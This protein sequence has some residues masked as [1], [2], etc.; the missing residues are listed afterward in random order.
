MYT[1]IVEKLNAL[2]GN[3]DHISAD[4]TFAENWQSIQFSGYLYDK[5]WDVYGIDAFYEK[6]K[7][8]YVDHNEKFY[9]DLIEHYFSEHEQTYG[10]DFYKDW[11][12]TPFKKDSK[13]D[14]ELDGFVEEDEL[15]KT[16]QGTEMDFICIIYSYGYPDHYFVCLTDPNPINPTVYST[17]H[18]VYFQ[19]IENEGSL[20]DFLDRYMTKEAFVGVV[21]EYLEEKFGK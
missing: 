7:E 2:G 15:R 19:K 1:K 9:E 14:G 20:E 5:E 18:E 3:T 13:D 21:K 10:Q 16:V 6:N 8:T 4:K 11:L 12:F 17:D